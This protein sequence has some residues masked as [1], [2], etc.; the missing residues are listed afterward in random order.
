[1]SVVSDQISACV[2]FD[3]DLL[4]DEDRRKPVKESWVRTTGRER[5]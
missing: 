3:D 5:R 1:V 4:D 2:E